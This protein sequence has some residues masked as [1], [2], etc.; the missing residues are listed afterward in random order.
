VSVLALDIGSSRIKALLAD[1]DGC[2]IEVRSSA[3][4]HQSLEPGE[5]SYPIETVYA[6]IEGLVTD[7]SAS[8]G[9]APIDTLV[10]SCLGTAMAPVDRHGRPLGPALAPA[11]LRP[12]RQPWPID[13]LEVD[14]AELF[15]RTGSDP[16]V[17]SFLLHWLWWRD[18]HPELMDELYRFRSLRGYAVA[19]LCDADAEDR[20]WASRTMLADLGTGD[21]SAKILSAAGLPLAAL[22]TIVPATTKFPIRADVVDRLGLA[23]GAVAVLG[24][25]DNGCALIGADGPDRSGLVN[26]VGTYEHM[27]AAADLETVRAVA[28]VS[29]AIIHAY[30]LPDQ[31]ITMT[32][33]PIGDLLGRA[34]AGYRGGLDELLGGVSPEPQG[35]T[36]SLDAAAVEAVVQAGHPR[37][38]LV[39]GLIESSATVLRRFTEAWAAQGKPSEPIAVVGGGAGPESVL[40][41]KAAI[42]GRRLVTLGNSE[43]AGLGALRLAAMAIHG[44]TA[45]EACGLFENPIARTIEPRRSA[46]AVPAEGVPRP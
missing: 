5:R 34:A 14:V 43:A 11:D 1:W 28:D 10:F 15:E 40:R 25:M 13:V 41:L 35:L 26:I 27:T 23:P 42:L 17:A 45:S 3:T 38:R 21:W 31:F 33:V 8:H 18:A 22:P 46:T 37:Q 39:Q 19:E 32:R 4:P 7:L 6:A 29:D 24:G 30:P 20:S 16:S 12:H 9:A 36:T 2:L 44:A